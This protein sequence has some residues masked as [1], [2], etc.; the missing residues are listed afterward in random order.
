MTLPK[1]YQTDVEMILA[2]RYDNG[3]DLWATADGR[4]GVGSPFSTLDCALMLS[5]LGMVHSNPFLKRTAELIMSSWRED[6]RFRI[7]PKGAIYPCHTATVARTLCH[8]GY[9]SDSRLKKTFDHLLEIQHADGGWRCNTYKFGRGPETAF[10]NPGPTLAALDAFR[11]APLLNR[12][13]HLDKAVEFLLSHWV[14]RKPLGPCHFGIGSLF[15]KVE[16]PFFRYNLFFYVYVLS[17]YNKA[18]KDPRFLEAL[19]NLESKLIDGKVVVENP[20]RKLAGFSFCKKGELS[21]LATIRY[22]EILKNIGR[23][24]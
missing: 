4:L 9:A 10:S 14:T 6:G 23:S 18:K 8:L 19:S 11:F 15:M 2:R 13:K 3:G 1:R 5:E 12:D 17:F 20:N 21:E 16:F 22:R 7:A 24:A